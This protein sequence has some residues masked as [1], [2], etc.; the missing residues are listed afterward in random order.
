MGGGMGGRPGDP[1]GVPQVPQNAAPGT[2]GVLHFKHALGVGLVAN[3]S[4]LQA[5]DRRRLAPSILSLRNR[6][7]NIVASRVSFGLIFV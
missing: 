2:S 4:S 3:L 5:Q 1:A 7:R 6:R